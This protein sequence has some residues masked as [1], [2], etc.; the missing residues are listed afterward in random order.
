MTELSRPIAAPIHHTNGAPPAKPIRTLGRSPSFTELVYAHYDWWRAQ[1]TGA[2]T[3]GSDEAYEALLRRFSAAHGEIVRSYWCS[4]VESAVALT[5][6]RRRLRWAPRQL[7]YHRETDWATKNQPDI[8]GELHRCDKLAVRA[9]TVL[10]GVRQRI[11]LQLVMASA[12]HLLSLVD[13]RAAHDDPAKNAA[14]LAQERKV[15]DETESYYAAAANGQAQIVYFGGMAAAAGAITLI[16]SIWLWHAS[17]WP[18]PVMALLAGSIGAVVSVIQRINA[19]DFELDYDVG[20]P[21]AFFLG[22]LRPLI[23]GAMAIAIAFVFISGMLSLPIAADASADQKRFALLVV[24]F[25]A[26][27]SER[28]AQDTLATAVPG[29][30]PSGGAAAGSAKGS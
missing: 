15:I 1:R 6:R 13:A 7:A 5:E 18:R 17:G 24:S 10:K 21:Y 11:C 26:G 12:A 20:W 22:G 2:E 8:A 9:Q 14:T 16:C 27:F 19:G 4:N 3:E 23:G 28:W 30:K 25:L 29:T